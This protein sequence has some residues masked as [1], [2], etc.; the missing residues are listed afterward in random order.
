MTKT[1]GYSSHAGGN[2]THFGAGASDTMGDIMN[3]PNNYDE[4]R[5]QEVHFSDGKTYK[6]AAG[7][8]S[9]LSDTRASSMYPSNEMSASSFPKAKDLA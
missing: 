9:K 8:N 2:N 4:A 5:A 3:F 7:H 6:A 1:T